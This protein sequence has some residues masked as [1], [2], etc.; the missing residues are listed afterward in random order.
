MIAALFATVALGARALTGLESSVDP[1]LGRPAIGITVRYSGALPRDV[2]R[3]VVRPI[4]RHVAG[5][6]GI[7]RTEATAQEGKGRVVVYFDYL[8]QL[9]GAYRSI[10]DSVDA[11]R[12]E[13]PPGADAPMISRVDPGA[14]AE[15]GSGGSLASLGLQLVTAGA[16]ALA[17]IVGVGSSWRSALIVSLA[18]LVSAVGTLEIVGI[19][20]LSLTPATRLGLALAMMFVL[21]DAIIVR[22]AIVRQA[23]LGLA[24]R[25][26]AARGAKNVIRGLAVAGIGTHLVF[27]LVAAIGGA[28]GRWFA[29]V[30]IVVMSAVGVS[31]LVT[32]ILVPAASTLRSPSPS[33]RTSPETWSSRRDAWF[34]ALADRHH[35]LL[36]WSLG[37]RRAIAAA[38]L[39]VAVGFA[40]AMANG[41]IA[42]A[43]L[44]SVELELR[45]PDAHTLFGVA[46]R[47]ADEIRAVHGV[48]APVVSTTPEGDGEGLARIDHIDGGRVVRVQATVDHR[49]VAEVVNDMNA[50]I[51]AIPFPPGYDVRYGGELADRAFTIRR[52]GWAF[53]AALA[54]AGALLAARFR[55]LLAPLAIFAG[56]AV[57][58]AGAYAALLITGTRLDVLTLI[59]G[60]LLAILVVRHGVQLLA[61]YRDRRAH[62]ANDRVSLI[63][64]GRARLRPTFISGV[65]MIGALVPIALA[66]D[67][68]GGVSHS[69]AIALVGGV[70]AS[71]VATLVVVPASYAVLED[72]ALVLATGL[73]ASLARGKRRIR[74]LPGAD[75]QG[76][77]GS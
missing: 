39:A 66:P 10:R 57:V 32:A 6:R 75:D 29:G 9:E 62:D 1:G 18:L 74:P 31:L 69:I 45:G 37:A 36:A 77:V 30:S 47:V 11:A 61:A 26:A 8:R 59:A 15:G 2:E 52:A 67:G 16:L 28:S 54:L 25:S 5:V 64:A 63:E 35:E 17:F 65:A 3:E 68:P 43:T 13:L 72:V 24:P 34:E 56:V 53:G 38:A 71:W 40:A 48:S 12:R 76:V 60:A 19:G 22:E 21:D 4:E 46:Q 49:R 50:R 23:E 20:G 7:V 33:S 27:G 41:A 14:D 70:M 44:P 42:D 58:W 55:T 73:R 51:A